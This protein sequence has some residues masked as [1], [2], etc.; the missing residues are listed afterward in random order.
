[1]V[2]CALDMG[3]RVGEIANLA[4]ADIDW[5]AGTVT[6]QGTKS[7]REDIL[8]LPVATGE[9]IA[10]Y[11]RYERPRTA[12]PAVFVRR[13]APHDVPITP[14]AVHRLIRDAFRRIGLNH[15]RTH[16]L[17]HTLAR[18]EGAHDV[19]RPPR[20]RR[21]GCFVDVCSSIAGGDK[22]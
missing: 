10:D 21:A 15:G 1:M 4:L 8:P 18:R 2:R 22:T 5:H 16:A 9:A 11:L 3:L 20:S 13:L 7:R 17:R 12:N 19:R 6:L 14:Y